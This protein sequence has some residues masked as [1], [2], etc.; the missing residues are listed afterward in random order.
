MM[1]N[2]DKLA[3]YGRI[4]RENDERIKSEA[5]ATL[6]RSRNQKQIDQAAKII[7]AMAVLESAEAGLAQKALSATAA[8]YNYFC[9][10]D[11]NGA[12]EELRLARDILGVLL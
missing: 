10:T 4:R 12:N 5:A 11:P 6:E 2:A 3:E 1:T 8:R 7:T 9:S